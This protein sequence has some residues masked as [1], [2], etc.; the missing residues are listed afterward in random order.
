MDAA[1]KDGRTKQAADALVP[2]A[3]RL[4]AA[5]QSPSDDDLAGPRIFIAL[6]TQQLARMLESSDTGEAVL[7]MDEGA[8]VQGERTVLE[9]RLLEVCADFACLR[10]RTPQPDQSAEPVGATESTD[11]PAAV[12]EGLLDLNTATLEELQAVPHLG[13]ERAR[14]LVA[15]RPIREVNEL[16][17]ID[18]IGPKRVEDIRVH[19]VVCS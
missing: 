2:T 9:D 11:T 18:G 13:A 15:M 16:T 17:A 4:E 14:A 19:G 12:D 5:R 7:T 3:E 8:L 10:F 1:A 6:V